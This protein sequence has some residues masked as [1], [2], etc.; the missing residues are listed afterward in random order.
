MLAIIAH[1]RQE[2]NKRAE[3][4]GNDDQES[5]QM[6]CRKYVHTFYLS[7]LTVFSKQTLLGLTLSLKNNLSK[8]FREKKKKQ[9]GFSFLIDFIV[10][11]VVSRS[12]RIAESEGARDIFEIPNAKLSG[13]RNFLS[14]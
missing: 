9:D 1:K 6:S 11:G 13:S 2:V 5:M 3:R 10:F 14:I 4:K 8:T 7:C 12:M